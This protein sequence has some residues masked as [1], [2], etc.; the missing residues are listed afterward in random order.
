MAAIFEKPACWRA[1]A[2]QRLQ[3]FLHSIFSSWFFR[4]NKAQQG[5]GAATYIFKL[6]LE[7]W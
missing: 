3:G 7:M 6:L 2:Y 4:A 5:V 1:H